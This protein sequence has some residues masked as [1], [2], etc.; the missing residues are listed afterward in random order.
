MSE[1]TWFDLPVLGAMSPEQAIP[2]LRAIGEFEVADQFEKARRDLHR[3]GKPDK[4]WWPFPKN[5][6]WQHTTH[7]FGHIRPSL[8]GNDPQPIHPIE[9]IEPEEQLRNARITITLN[10]LRAANYPGR[11]MHHILVHFGIHNQQAEQTEQLHFNATYR[12]QEG[13]RAGI[14]GYPVFVGL[15]VGSEGIVL[16]C[17]TINVFN[18]QDRA[19]LQILESD[20]I[21]MG[22]R[23][24]NMVQPVIAPFSDMAVNLVK[25]FTTRH[26]NSPVQDFNLGL[27]FN[28]L[29][30]GGRL[31]E[32]TYLAVQVPEDQWN[33]WNWEEW[34]YLPTRGRVVQRC[35]YQ[36]SIPY[37]YLAFGI[38]RYEKNVQGSTEAKTR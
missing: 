32:G 31:A 2:R 37:N 20:T 38:S 28:T 25:A 24:T 19:L 1:M 15:H 6:P 11:G 29:A 14:Q 26:E 3:G 5:Q 10:R 12:V 22:L 16:K 23:L 4:W 7:V 34:V 36:Q 17:C 13:E 18:E 9:A 30:L 8:L 35:E 21:K 27:S 33:A